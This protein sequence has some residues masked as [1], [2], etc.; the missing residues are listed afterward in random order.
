MKSFNSYNRIL[1]TGTPLQNNLTE[2]WSLLNFLLP[3]IFNNL[4]VFQ[5]W[6]DA[7]EIQNEEG[8]KKF[9]QQEQ[10]KNVL[11][12]LREILQPFMLR[13]LKE[14]VCPDVPP[15][16]EVMIYAPLTRIQYDLYS[17]IINKDINKLHK[18]KK[19]SAIVDVNG[20]RPKRKCRDKV[21][22]DDIYVSESNRINQSNASV[23]KKTSSEDISEWKEVME[24]T[25]ENLDYLIRI[26]MQNTCEYNV[27]FFFNDKFFGQNYL[28]NCFF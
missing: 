18:T 23:E 16:K 17:A 5:S 4:Q 14:D 13:R 1:L 22:L 3:D 11:G 10:E 8:R 27:H 20:V 2:L 28:T 15:L 24:V 9:L 7:K 6:F 25:E 21:N 12:A 26:K 19:V